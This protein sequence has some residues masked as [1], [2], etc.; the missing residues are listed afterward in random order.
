MF[1]R[2]PR[3]RPFMLSRFLYRRCEPLGNLYSLSKFGFPFMPPGSSTSPMRRL[4]AHARCAKFAHHPPLHRWLARTVMLFAW[5]FGALVDTVCNLFYSDCP[6]NL[7]ALLSR[8]THMLALALRE[9]V[10]PLEYI[11][12]RLY[13]PE[14][15][16]R[17]S[18]YLYWSEDNIFRF[19]NERNGANN[20]DVQDKARFADICRQH[21]LPCIQTLAVYRGGKQVFPDT[22]FLP[23]QPCL[24]VKDL[25]G[26][27]G[28]GAG[29]WRLRDGMYHDT[30]GRS[31]SPEELVAAWCKRGCIVQ[32]C[33]NNHPQLDCLS[34]SDGTLADIRIISGIEP[35]SRV[36]LI[37][38]QITLPWG[39]FAN[40]PRSA[41]G[42]L[43]D[44][45]RIVRT[46]Y[47]D[48][49]PVERHPETG[50]VFAEVVVPWWR[51]A[52]EL[53]SR[54]HSQAFPRFVFLGWDVA[55]TAEGPVLI[56]TNSGPGVLHHQLLDDI[57]LG[58]TAFPMIANQYL[59]KTERCA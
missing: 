28:S 18:E 12:Y 7:P 4:R 44:E 37:T 29:K 54:A 20:D 11:I 6:R 17:A 16:G 56:E 34:G 5:P 33:L 55:I 49:K 53:V 13:E 59:T 39:G 47:T 19:L 46:L 42:L 58:H 22:P 48:G 14:R 41:M 10:M 26:K 50:A 43:D 40:R 30:A 57:P 52:Q 27:Q 51:E 15:R 2:A 9:N 35:D 36:H 8:G 31:R 25:A 21:G 1:E 23:D 32:P 45:G 24:W 3:K 38:H